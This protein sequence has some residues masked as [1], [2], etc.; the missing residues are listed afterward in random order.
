LRAYQK[1]PAPVLKL[2]EELKDDPE[3]YVRRSVANNL[4]D[5]GKDHPALLV[6]VARRWWRGAS[7][8]RR[9]IVRHALRSLVKRGNAS[10]LKLL[11]FGGKPGVRIAR[12]RLPK[13]ARI[14]ETLRFEVEIASTSKTPQDLM[15]DYAV[16]FVK[17]NG[18]ASPKVFKLR[19]LRL[20]AGE[21]VGLQG[22][23]SLKVHTTRTPRPGRHALELIANGARLPLGAFTVECSPHSGS[24]RSRNQKVR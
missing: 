18:K 24:Q 2:L 11:G 17:A 13:R 5:I 12:V 7:E 8:E 14:G 23:V 3:L 10:A 22:R 9:W 6:D 1:D 15:I 21:R 20:A 16:H 4:N 19:K